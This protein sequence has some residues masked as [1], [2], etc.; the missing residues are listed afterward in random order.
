ML[1]TVFSTDV[2]ESLSIPIG[3]D[4]VTVG[5]IVLFVRSVY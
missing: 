4:T 2:Y 5:D 3:A 1:V